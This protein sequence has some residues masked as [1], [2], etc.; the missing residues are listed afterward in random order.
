[1]L[2]LLSLCLPG[3]VMSQVVD[4]FSDGDF[5]NGRLW[6]GDSAAFVVMNEVLKLNSTGSDSSFLITDG[7]QVL[8]TMEWRFK[9]RLDFAPSGF[10]YARYYLCSDSDD[11]KSPLSGYFL[12]FGESG[13]A[14]AVALYKQIGT[15]ISLIT[16]AT[17]SLIASPFDIRIR[18]LRLPSG[19]WELWVDYAG[20][21]AFY[22]QSSGLE[23]S[24]QPGPYTGWKCIY[25][26]SNA[27][28]FFLDDVYAGAYLYDTI[29]PRI[30]TAAIGSDSLISVIFDEEP[31]SVSAV[32][33]QHYIID[34][35]SQPMSVRVDS[36]NSKTILLLFSQAFSSNGI[37]QLNVHGIMDSHGNVSPDTQSIQLFI[38][39]PAAVSDLVITEI[40]SDPTSAPTLPPYEYL[41]IYNRSQKVILLSG[42]KLSDGS[43]D[44]YLPQDTIFPGQYRAYTE[45]SVVSFFHAAGY[46]GMKGVSGFP[47]LN[48]DGDRLKIIDAN[49]STL[50]IIQYDVSMYKD[51]L[52][53]DKGWSLERIDADFPC[54]DRNN[55]AAS[56][57]PSGGTPGRV[58]SKAGFFS[59]TI[60]PWPV[61]AFPED[62][63]TLKVCFSEAVDSVSSNHVQLYTVIDGIGEPSSIFFLEEQSCFTLKFN[64]PFQPDVFYTL[65]F[66][67]S[68][69][70]CAGNTIRRWTSLPFSIPDSIRPGDIII[71]EILFNPIDDGSDFVEIQNTGDHSVDLSLLRIAHADP[72]TGIVDDILPFSLESRLLLPGDFAVATSDYSDILKRYHLGD[73]RQLIESS[74][75][76]F[77]DDEGIVVLLNS[78]FIELERFHYKDDFH[79]KLL[80]DPEGVSLERISLL[81]AVNDSSNWHSAAENVGFASPCALNS[82]YYDPKKLDEQWLNLAPELFSPDN[83]GYHDVLGISCKPSR[84]GYMVALSIYNEFGI[85]V[86]KL[87]QQELIGGEGFWIWDGLSDQ[88]ELQGAGIYVVVLE[89]FHIDGDTRVIKKAAVLAKKS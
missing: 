76:S 14:D 32:N 84:P 63:T 78:S 75:P 41:E 88:G 45:S 20:G 87:T 50:D 57:D 85:P 23:N 10:N 60:A 3:T 37:Y 2:S 52:R 4:D 53:D 33:T 15:S 70:D 34:G 26:S 51:P 68:I 29:P 86:R 48:N 62:S 6:T 19:Q 73:I 21:E 42:Y 35:G 1:M 55:W 47:T 38:A 8:D 7:I 46:S 74:L 77:N 83:D 36:T 9:I 40:M 18:V 82:Q 24:I 11:L 80:S 58:N 25:T 49:G 56:H 71:N 54:S 65:S 79:F 66:D 31:D 5:N 30:I 44:A 22:F 43:T 67:P 72:L 59:D 28:K 64:M 39:S 89:M 81:G 17:D 12:Q 27:D 61:Y 69:Q 13:S 16:R